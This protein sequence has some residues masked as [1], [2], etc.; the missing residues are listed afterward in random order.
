MAFHAVP[1]EL[2]RQVHCW[3]DVN[4]YRLR[5]GPFEG[6]ANG[7]PPAL[8]EVHDFIGC[9]STERGVGP[10]LKTKPVVLKIAAIISYFFSRRFYDPLKQIFAESL[11]ICR[12]PARVTSLRY[13]QNGM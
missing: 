6:P 3:F 5:A 9:N 12:K 11:N 1:S 4:L 7:K 8:P 10:I 2:D 13:L